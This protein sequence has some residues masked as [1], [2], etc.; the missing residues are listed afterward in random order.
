MSDDEE[1]Q[2]GPAGRD[3]PS[4]LLI[5]TILVVVVAVIFVFQ[6]R[7]TAQVNFLLFDGEFRVWTALLF[8]I[9]LGIVLDRLFIRWRRRVKQQRDGD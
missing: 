6:N 9:V 7:Q 3:G 8:A 4:A 1:R 5:L 2:A